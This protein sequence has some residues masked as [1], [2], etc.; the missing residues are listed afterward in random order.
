MIE[1]HGDTFVVVPAYNEAQQIVSV[2]REV[3]DAGY[4]VVVVDDGSDDGTAEAVAC[5]PVHR[6][7]HPINIGQG[8][9]LETGT[10]YA[11]A[12]GAS[13]VVHFDADGQHRVSDIERLLQPLRDGTAEVVLGSRF[14]D[15]AGRQAVPPV[16]RWLLRAGIVVNGVLTGLWL[17]DAHNGLRAMT[18]NAATAIHLR[19][20]GYAHASEIL[21]QI[22]DRRLRCVE[23]PTTILYTEY[24]RRKGQP[25]WNA[26]NIV[27]DLLLRKLFP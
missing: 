21:S 2:V 4:R 20:S 8:A 19:E 17:N 27:F 22:R 26:L 16:K 14:L 15:A 6:V 23:R 9:A 5:L 3:T 18:R 25:M 7:R 13:Y 10:R 12:Q 24:A 11:L 1:V